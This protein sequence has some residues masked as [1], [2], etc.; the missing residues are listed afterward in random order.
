MLIAL[1]HLIL[2]VTNIIIYF[3]FIY[4]NILYNNTV[5]YNLNTKYRI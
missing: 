3:F 4:Y 5:F 2:T 1:T